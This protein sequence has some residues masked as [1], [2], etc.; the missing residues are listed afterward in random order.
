MMRGLEILLSQRLKDA[1]RE[2][3]EE[4]PA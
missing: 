4:A 1:P 3:D 2:D